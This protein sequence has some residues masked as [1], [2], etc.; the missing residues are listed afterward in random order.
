MIVLWEK[1]AGIR[2]SIGAVNI[3]PKNVT[4]KNP[5]NDFGGYYKKQ[6]HFL[7]L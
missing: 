3:F 2:E 6:I 4:N 5:Q 7:H 1:Y